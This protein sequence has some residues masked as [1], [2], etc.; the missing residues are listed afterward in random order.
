LGGG[1]RIFFF[2]FPLFPTCS[3]FKFPMGSP[4][5]FPI[6]PHPN[7][8]CFAQSPSLL[9]YIA[10]PKGEALHLSRES[11]IMGSL[12]NSIFLWPWANQIGSL[13]KQKVGLV[14]HPW[15]INMEQNKYPRIGIMCFVEGCFVEGVLAEAQ[16]WWQQC[17]GIEY[18]C[19]QW[20]DWT[21]TQ[22]GSSFP[23]LERGR[24]ARCED[25]IY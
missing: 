6:A 19:S 5:M 9:T 18:A 12:H 8:I 2:F 22:E 11:S 4:K 17:L 20:V 15:L 24:G 14:R 23:L 13:Q 10:G 1:G 21:Y 16:K 25:G 3:P 7:P